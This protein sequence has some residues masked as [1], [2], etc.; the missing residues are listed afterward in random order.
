MPDDSSWQEAVALPP[1]FEPTVQVAAGVLMTDKTG[2]LLLVK[3]SYS[4]TWQIPGGVV[5]VGESPADAA[6]REVREELGI[7]INVGP[8]L[9]VDYRPP[10]AGGRGDALR[11]VFRADPLT[12]RQIESIELRTS[13]LDGWKLMDSGTIDELVIPVLARR[14]RHMRE[15]HIYLEEGRPRRSP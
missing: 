7:S 1:W 8:L 11:F 15:G 2:R 9:G 14:I 5:E 4:E 3:P 13:E 6:G 12:Q 10:V